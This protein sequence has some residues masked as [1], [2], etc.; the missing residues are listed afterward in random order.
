MIEDSVGRQIL[1][2]FWSSWMLEMT[3]TG[4]DG[5]DD[6]FVPAVIQAA[7]RVPDLSSNR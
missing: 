2:A 4:D 1:H 5:G 6:L 7:W 3:V